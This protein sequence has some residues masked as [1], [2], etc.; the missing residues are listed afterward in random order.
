VDLFLVCKGFKGID[1]E[2]KQ[3]LLSFTGEKWPTSPDGSAK[4]LLHADDADAATAVTHP[5]PLSGPAPRGQNLALVPR[6]KIPDAFMQSML[7]GA[8]YFARLQEA[9]IK[10]NLR[11][12]DE[13][14]QHEGRVIHL[15]RQLI[16]REWPRRFRIERIADDQRI[17]QQKKLSGDAKGNR[18][19]GPRVGGKR[20]ETGTLEERKAKRARFQLLFTTH[21]QRE[22]ACTVLL[23]RSCTRLQQH[24]SH[25]RAP[26]LY[27][28]YGILDGTSA[29]LITDDEGR[30]AKRARFQLLFTIHVQREH[31]C[32]VLLARSCTR[33]Q[34]HSSHARAPPLYRNNET[35]DQKFQRIDPSELI[36]IGKDILKNTPA[37]QFDGSCQRS[38]LKTGRKESEVKMSKFC[39]GPTLLKLLEVRSNLQLLQDKMEITR[40]YFGCYQIDSVGFVSRSALKLADIHSIFTI[41][42]QHKMPDF[43]GIFNGMDGQDLSFIDLYGGKGGFSDFVLC[44][45]GPSINRWWLLN[46]R[47]KK[48]P[49]LEGFK[50]FSEDRAVRPAFNPVHDTEVD[51]SDLESMTAFL[52][53]TG[54]ITNPVGAVFGDGTIDEKSFQELDSAPSRVLMLHETD[55]YAD[56]KAFLAK[57]DFDGAAV[58]AMLAGSMEISI[59]DGLTVPAPV[60]KQWQHWN[61]SGGHPDKG[62]DTEN[63]HALK[64]EYNAFKANFEAWCQARDATGQPD[65]QT[66]CQAMPTSRGPKS[67]TLEPASV[68]PFLCQAWAALR[69]L[70]QGGTFICKVTDSLGRCTVGTYYLLCQCFGFVTIVKPST[71]SPAKCERFLIALN[72]LGHDHAIVTNI[73]DHLA[74][75]LRTA[76][77]APSQPT[78]TDADSCASDPPETIGRHGDTPIAKAGAANNQTL[79]GNA[80]VVEIVPTPMLFKQPF[81]DHLTKLNERCSPHLC[82][83]FHTCCCP[84]ELTEP[85]LKI[86]AFP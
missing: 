49:D 8:E 57:L 79:T 32:T 63:Y 18:V 29:P 1:E 83:V 69:V 44:K 23:A 7:S 61:L 48:R 82:R 41:A 22:H 81:F 67:R 53:T 46:R 51:A 60:K 2:L 5:S 9:V 26:P 54:A 10:R 72:F 70:R 12:F 75:A 65:F 47:G 59:D 20:S 86:A 31:A 17:V 40:K 85:R 6:E 25:A 35:D 14:P 21:V 19:G 84:E 38:W 45:Y 68:K 58:D 77:T 52:E 80:S 34:Q 13:F 78:N 56:A 27:R 30:K 43:S 28:D 50:A 55:R 64:G 3:A 76:S 37:G 66:W 16:V 4:R 11:L 71:S 36:W 74:H 24:S 73:R 33:V 42:M 39:A 62:G 15:A